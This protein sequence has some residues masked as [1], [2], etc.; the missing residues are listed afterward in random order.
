MELVMHEFRRADVFGL[1]W[2]AVGLGCA[3]AVYGEEKPRK[4]VIPVDQIWAYDM[5]GTRPMQDGQRDGKY[6]AAEGELL[7]E[8]RRALVRERVEGTSPIQ[9]KD[10]KLGFAV[11]GMGMDALREAHAVLVKKQEPRKSFPAGTEI[12]LVFF[13][14]QFGPYVHIHRVERQDRGVEIRYRF[15]LHQ[16]D[17]VTEHLALIPLG[18]PS[19]GRVQV[20]IIQSPMEQKYV[21]GGGKPISCDQARPVVCKSFSFELV[22]ENAK[23]EPTSR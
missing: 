15:V 14:N 21:D 7:D 9:W 16:I 22:D 4:V 11:L 3:Y 18:K 23:Q 10:A 6:V 12:T 8:I 1:V 13:S 20:E 2:L 17:V 5:P 19:V